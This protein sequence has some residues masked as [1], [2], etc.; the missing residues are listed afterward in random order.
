[1]SS[2][3]LTMGISELDPQK[4][5]LKGNLELNKPRFG[6]YGSTMYIDKYRNRIMS[7]WL[8]FVEGNEFHLN[9]YSNGI[10]YKLNKK[11]KIYEIDSMEDYI[12]LMNK[13][14]LEGYC[15]K[16]MIDWNK[17]SKDYDAFHLTEKA[18]WKLRMIYSNKHYIESL[19]KIVTMDDFYSYDCETWIIF[20]LD[21]I[22][23]GSIQNVSTKLQCYMEE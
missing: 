16:Y 9:R 2:R 12:D 19:G 23:K 17:F 22:N 11:A 14:P 10:S 13:Y 5:N 20:N 3:I 4:F 18:F 21:C 7:S 1:M 15:D 8:E 6:L